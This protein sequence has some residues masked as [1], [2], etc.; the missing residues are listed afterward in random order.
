MSDKKHCSDCGCDIRKQDFAR[1]LGTKKHLAN[2]GGEPIVK[3]IV[4][5]VVVSDETD[6]ED[7]DD[8]DDENENEGEP[9]I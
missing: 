6:N 4:P 7:D 3:P 5:P 2:V 8:D 9:I 1:H